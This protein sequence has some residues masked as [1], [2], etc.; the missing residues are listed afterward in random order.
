MG[1]NDMV[2]YGKAIGMII[3]IDAIA[4]LVHVQ[5]PDGYVTV[6]RPH[7]LQLIERLGTRPFISTNQGH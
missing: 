7:K 6:V 4:K 3:K 1:V 2:M 5:F